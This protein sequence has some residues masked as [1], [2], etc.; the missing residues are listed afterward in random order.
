MALARDRLRKSLEFFE[1]R[2]NAADVFRSSLE[3]ASFGL[4]LGISSGQLAALSAPSPV[5]AARLQLLIDALQYVSIRLND[6]LGRQALIRW[7]RREIAAD[8]RYPEGLWW[9]YAGLAVKDFHGDTIALLD[10]TA[11]VVILLD[12]DLKQKDQRTL[13]AFPDVLPSS[14]RTYRT[15]LAPD[16]A[17]VVDATDSW[18]PLVKELRDICAHRE[19]HRL[20]FNEAKD[21]FHFQVYSKDLLQPIVNQPEFAVV[22]AHGIADFLLYSAW[23]AGEVLYYLDQLAQ[24]IRN[25]F[26]IPS[27][28]LYP[29]IREGSYGE[30][31]DNLMTL[32]SGDAEGRA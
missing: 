9:S 32:S 21:G 5:D 1:V 14:K 17:A 28:L 27:S 13:P 7:L 2:E 29:T 22:K 3:S 12:T 4:R 23:V 19:H 30:L 31:V 15:L 11:P 26:G 16:T 25:R 10:S 20:V 18:W 24:L 6:F 8:P